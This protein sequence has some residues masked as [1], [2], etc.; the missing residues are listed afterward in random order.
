V[1]ILR[2][3]GDKLGLAWALHEVAIVHMDLG[4]LDAAQVA[5]EENYA[6]CQELG[7]R[8]DLGYAAGL[9]ALVFLRRGQADAA[10][11][12]AKEA[13]AAFHEFGD[14]WGLAVALAGLGIL[15]AMQG[16]PELALRLATAAEVQLKAIGGALPAGMPVWLERVVGVARR[17]LG[18]RAAAIQAE[19]RALT[20]DQATALAME[21]V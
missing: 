5:E 15:A 13:L 11:P 18:D 16:Q 10:R 20:F 7:D 6:L 14:K 3:L 4:D 19:G 8:R 9:L 12:L 17:T 21:L 2:Q 1:P